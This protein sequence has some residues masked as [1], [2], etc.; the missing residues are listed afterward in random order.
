M[1]LKITT[2]QI[3]DVVESDRFEP[4]FHHIFSQIKKYTKELNC[5]VKNFGEIILEITDGEHAGQTFVEEGVRFIKNTAVK[6]FQID[7]SHGFYITKE[8]HI[9]QTRSSLKHLDILF[10][11]I[12]QLGSSTVI[13]KDFGEANINQ[14]L[15]RIDIDKN[16]IS[17]Y[18]LVVYLNSK[19]V[20]QQIESLF[21]GNIQRILTYPKIKSIKIIIPKM[22]VHDKIAKKCK[23]AETMRGKALSLIEQAKDIFYRE[24][25][26]DF[27]SLKRE[28]CF[29]MNINEIIQSGVFTPENYQPLYSDSI[30]KIQ[31]K[32]RTVSLGEIATVKKGDEVGSSNYRKYLDK[33]RN[34]VPFIRTS[35]IQN[36]EVDQYPDF[37]VSEEYYDELNQGIISGDVLFTNDGKIGRVAIIT[38]HDRIILQ[39]HINRLRLKQEAKIEHGLSPEYLFLVLTLKEISMYQAKRYTI[40]QST[41]PTISKNILEFKIPI[42]DKPIM[43]KITKI[44]KKAT[45][46]MD[47]SKK[48][49]A[50]IREYIDSQY[51]IE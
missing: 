20:K 9:E 49:I 40:V 3:P 41:I 34:D 37:Y 15:V 1:A 4:R 28:K 44:V 16:I 8:K 42:L 27:S 11:T 38:P 50:E 22:E 26:V 24:L 33:K 35:D 51:E 43:Q 45:K 10:T 32:C 12:G 23:S 19:I 39:S 7:L 21:T 2:A 47:N 31:E 6:D 36:Y 14:N 18:Y 30:E 29:S 17:P 13:P 25:N 46:L 48:T 5:V